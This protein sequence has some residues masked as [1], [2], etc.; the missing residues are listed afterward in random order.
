MVTL[1]PDPKP[2]PISAGTVGAALGG[3]PRGVCAP[4]DAQLH[5]AATSPHFNLLVGF[6]AAIIGVTLVGRG[7]A[8]CPRCSE[9]RALLDFSAGRACSDLCR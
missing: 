1:S 9:A 8:G 6:W 2:G 7:A 5:P 4:G 3:T